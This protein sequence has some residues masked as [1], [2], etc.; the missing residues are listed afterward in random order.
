MPDPRAGERVVFVAHFERGFGLPVSTFFR[1][2]LDF[3]RLQP[4]HLTANFIMTMSG[5]VTLFKGYLGIRP[6]I[7]LWKRLFHIRGH[8]AR[9]G[10]MLSNPEGE[11][12]PPIYETAMTDCKDW[13]TTFFYVRSPDADPDL[14]NLPEFQLA[15]PIEK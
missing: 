1:E 11:D 7:G 8:M 9:T 10:N 4:H 14:I 13:R 5:F 3:H 2:F 12:K 15:P 6:S